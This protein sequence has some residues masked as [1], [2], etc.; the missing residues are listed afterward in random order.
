MLAIDGSALLTGRADSLV[1]INGS[2][3][4]NRI[5]ASLDL[6]EFVLS[7]TM[8]FQVDGGEVTFDGV[9]VDVVRKR[10]LGDS[11]G[12]RLTLGG[13]FD[14]RGEVDVEGR[15]ERLDV[16]HLARIFAGRGVDVRG[17]LDAEVS[18]NGEARDPDVAFSWAMASPGLFDFGF[19]G[20]E[21]RGSY[22]GRA[23]LLERATLSAG[24]DTMSLTGT[25]SAASDGASE[26]DPS[27]EY[28]LRV[29]AGDFRL[30]RLRSLPPGMERISGVLNVDLSVSGRGDSVGVEGDLGLTGGEIRGFGLAHPI[31]KITVAARAQGSTIALTDA[32]AELGSGSVELSGL[33]DLSGEGGQTT[34]YARARLR[35][36]QIVIEDAFEGRPEGALDWGGTPARSTLRGEVV[37]RDAVVTRSVG[38]ADV[39]G[40]RPSVVIVRPERDPRADVQ[41]NIGLDIEDAIEVDS[42]VAQLSLTGGGL[43]RGTLLEPRVSGGIETDGGTFT[44]LDN[45]FTVETLSVSFPNPNR[46]DPHVSLTGVTEVED[47]SGESYSVTLVLDGYLNEAVPTLTS[48]PPL[49]EPDIASLLTFGTTFG[50]F[51]SGGSGSDTSG[52][53]FS[54]LARSAFFSS[55]FGLAES[56]LER[57]LGLDRVTFEE[58]PVE[59]WDLANTGVTIAKQFGDRVHVNYSTA[60]GRFS[61]QKVEVSFELT[62]KLWVET[63]TDPE[64][65]HAVGLKVQIPF[66]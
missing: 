15:L 41:L 54:N 59:S 55:A 58:A 39:V 32:R 38:L 19:D 48:T 24:G 17:E 36:P 56:A 28:D 37:L 34:F 57:L 10:V 60:V 18:V 25:V 22:A 49:S 1:S 23:F 35:S 50:G 31:R 42:N 61:G 64:G 65:N 12:G 29:A 66:R 8:F 46:R 2:G 47:R 45:E 6:V 44:Y 11:D 7:D 14:P 53:T 52:D 63:R 4:F 21:G 27:V 33:V 30:G 13:R 9:T 40:R 26:D 62:R 20:S 5:H 3:R 43:I 51:V 16:A